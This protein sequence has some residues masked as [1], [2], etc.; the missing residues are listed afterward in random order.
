MLKLAN[1]F[2]RTALTLTMQAADVAMRISNCSVLF[3]LA[4]V[5]V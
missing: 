2:S 4:T 1:G 3:S 5:T